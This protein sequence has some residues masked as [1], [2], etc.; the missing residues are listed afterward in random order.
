MKIVICGSRRFT[1]AIRQVEKKLRQKGHIVLA[2]ILNKNTNISKLPKDLKHY[3]FLGLTH[4]HFEFIRKADICF[5][6]NK[7]GYMG[8]STTT[9]N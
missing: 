3:A 2:P 7:N 4:H 9:W 6:Y 5:V 8:N 1:D